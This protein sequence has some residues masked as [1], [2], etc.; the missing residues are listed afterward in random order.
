MSTDRG[1]SPNVDS[2]L[3]RPCEKEECRHRVRLYEKKN[4]KVSQ[5]LPPSVRRTICETLEIKKLRTK[6]EE[7]GSVLEK[8]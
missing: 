2:L 8:K 6:D 7:V 4:G 5:A 1:I 3:K